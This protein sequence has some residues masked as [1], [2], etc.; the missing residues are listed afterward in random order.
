VNLGGLTNVLRATVFCVQHLLAL[1]QAQGPVIG[2][3]SLSNHERLVSPLTLSLSKG[4][5]M[6]HTKHSCPQ[7]VGEPTQIYT[8]ANI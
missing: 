5:R 6:L 1:R 7:H 3:V 4:E 2:M 8:G